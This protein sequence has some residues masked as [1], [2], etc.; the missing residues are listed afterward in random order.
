MDIVDHIDTGWPAKGLNP[1]FGLWIRRSSC[2]SRFSLRAF[3]QRGLVTFEGP[4]RQTT[5]PPPS[6]R[7]CSLS[8]PP[9]ASRQPRFRSSPSPLVRRRRLRRPPHQLRRRQPR[10]PGSPARIRATGRR[11]SPTTSTRRIGRGARIRR[12]SFHRLVYSARWRPSRPASPIPR[13]AAHWRSSPK[14]VGAARQR[15]SCS[16]LKCC[17]S[18]A[19]GGSP[20]SRVPTT[21]S[22]PLTLSRRAT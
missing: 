11:S 2:A 22:S 4:A 14:C 6:P 16:R 19:L 7:S 10:L 9:F 21:D 15:G 1:G 13:T 17:C 8:Q 3:D 12:R 20:R 18:R 5:L